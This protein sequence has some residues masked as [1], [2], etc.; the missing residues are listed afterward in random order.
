MQRMYRK[1][2]AAVVGVLAVTSF[3]AAQSPAP[4]Q[5]PAI[6]IAAIPVA[7]PSTPTIPPA[8][9]SPVSGGFNGV[10]VRGM[11]TRDAASAILHPPAIPTGT[12]GVG[13][14]NG[15]GS[16][17]SD[18]GF[19]FGSC[20]SYFEPCG[21]EPCSCGRLGGKFGGLCGGLCGGRCGTHP[22]GQ[23][24]PTPGPCQY[25]SYVDR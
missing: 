1:M 4:Q 17:K 5:F 9:V 18:L 12:Y 25:W 2:F 7:M 10:D 24:Y 23:P 16:I 19:M 8:T 15:C 11:S 14:S 6:P 21:P 22:M 13:C 3:A 20:K